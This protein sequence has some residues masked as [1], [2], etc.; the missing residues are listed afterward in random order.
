VSFAKRD[1]WL[2]RPKSESGAGNPP[3]SKLFLCPPKPETSSPLSRY[4]RQSVNWYAGQIQ[5]PVARLKFLQKAAPRLRPAVR[6]P[7]RMMG[8][9][10]ALGVTASLAAFFL[11][12]HHKLDQ[13]MVIQVRPVQSASGSSAPGVAVPQTP[14]EVWQVEKTAS[15]EV[16]SNGLRVDTRFAVPNHPRSYLAFPMDRP[17]QTEGVQRSVPA[18]IVFHTT[19]SR[20]AP[21]E[22]DQ[23][24]VLKKLG[25]S[26]LEYVRRE[27]AYH[28]LI[29]RFGRVYR[30]V[31][32]TDAANHSGNSIWAD[33]QWLYL[34]LNQ[35]FFGVSIEA[36]TEPG[37]VEAEM[38]PAQLRAAAML[39]EMLRSRYH[40]A[41]AN[42]VTHAQ[43][44]VNPANMQIGLH[45]DW[46]SS[47]PFGQLGLP[48][49][50]Q[51][52]LPALWASGFEYNP[53]YQHW[54][55]SRIEAGIQ[56]AEDRLNARAADAGMPVHSYRRLLQK[57][58]R[59]QLEAVRE[60]NSEEPAAAE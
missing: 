21:F 28:F 50:Y 52:A 1:S 12:Q 30:I 35:S 5:D 27:R 16:Y 10:A 32:E 26:L 41:A 58:Y 8:L 31:A 19:E 39:T 6:I 38:S 2:N 33:D 7:W 18:G 47:F 43:V 4:S 40:I 11:V 42:C 54:G 20:Q 37:Q 55:G 15:S 45:V 59:R 48:D 53:E 17:A 51:R 23:N 25:E 9:V 49:N 34:N 24:R 13:P 60:A 3:E 22:P 57:R 29:D 14:A 46:A 56:L 44:S 36:R